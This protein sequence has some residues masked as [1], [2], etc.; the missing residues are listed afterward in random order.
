M[1]VFC[2]L[3]PPLGLSKMQFRD[4]TFLHVSTKQS[5]FKV[6]TYGN[7]KIN[8]KWYFLFL[9]YTMVWSNKWNVIVIQ[10]IYATRTTILLLI[11]WPSRNV[12]DLIQISLLGLELI[13]KWSFFFVLKFL[14]IDVLRSVILSVYFSSV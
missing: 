4:V 2:H 5:N 8:W 12:F 6:E 1:A 3:T 13:N 7:C 9:K 11:P 10:R 14:P